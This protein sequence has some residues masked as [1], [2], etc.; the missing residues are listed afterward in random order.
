MGIEE[1]LLHQ[2]EVKGEKRGEKR[3]EKLAEK[4]MIDVIRNARLKGSSIEFI[5]DIVNLSV[6]KVR[7]ILDKM[8]VE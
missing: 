8:G 4:I 5:A 2:A 1:L 7:A 3:G 6:E